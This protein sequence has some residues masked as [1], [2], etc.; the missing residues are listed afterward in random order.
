[1][2]KRIAKLKRRLRGEVYHKGVKVRNGLFQKA[3]ELGWQSVYRLSCENFCLSNGTS[4]KKSSQRER[5]Q[6]IATEAAEQSHRQQTPNV[7][8]VEK[9]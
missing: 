2:D 9:H 7:S 8:L 1:M 3:R 6:K 4:Q 5:L